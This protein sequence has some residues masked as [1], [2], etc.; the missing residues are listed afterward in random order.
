MEC[1]INGA[2]LFMLI[3]G[4]PIQ[5]SREWAEWILGG[6]LAYFASTFLIFKLY[7]RDA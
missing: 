1:P 2:F 3:T 7:T 4:E 5:F 6:T